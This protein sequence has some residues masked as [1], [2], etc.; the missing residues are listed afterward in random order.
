MNHLNSETAVAQKNAAPVSM[1][2]DG[3]IELVM[4]RKMLSFQRSGNPFVYIDGGMVVVRRKPRG[5][6]NSEPEYYFNEYSVESVRWEGD[7]LILPDAQGF[8]CALEFEE[9]AL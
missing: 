8:E 4:M 3:L 2:L 7:T 5:Y 6:D 9:E 1:T